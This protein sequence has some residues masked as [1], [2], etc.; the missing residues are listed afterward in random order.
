MLQP[1]VPF[2]QIEQSQAGV[3]T[4]IAI[5]RY[6]GDNFDRPD[7]GPNGSFGGKKRAIER[8]SLLRSIQY[9]L[10]QN[11]TEGELYATT[12]GDAWGS[13]SVLDSYS[14]MHTCS[15]LLFLRRFIE[16]V[17]QYTGAKKVDV[18]A[19]SVGVV[20][21]RKALKGG[22]LVGTDGNCTLGAP[23][24]AKIDTFVGIAGPNYGLCVCQLAQTVP[25]WCNALDGLYPGYTCQDQL[26][27]GYTSGNCK[28]ENYSALLE[29]LNNDPAREAEH[30]YAMWSDVDEVLL[31]RGMTWGKPTSRIPGMNGR[32]VSDRNGH[33]AMKDL[34][35]LRQFEASIDRVD[36]ELKIVDSNIH[37]VEKESR[38]IRVAGE[39]QIYEMV[40]VAERQRTGATDAIIVSTGGVREEYCVQNTVIGVSIAENQTKI[41]IRITLCARTRPGDG[42]RNRRPQGGTSGN[43]KATQRTPDKDRPAH[44]ASLNLGVGVSLSARTKKWF[45]DFSA[46]NR[47]KELTH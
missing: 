20:L 28:Q 37:S 36:F 23:L 26:L 34:T 40:R 15:N 16:A 30:V 42:N 46:G 44:P 29:K 25:A 21:A 4:T 11:Y 10:E 41:T 12:W 6:E 13:G 5:N 39:E 17:I 7:V 31:F 43:A 9:F 1:P 3:H 32:W 19:H 2:V 18:I 45:S 14:T 38:T 8:V 47:Q 33:V 22:S 27:C 24:T 35:E